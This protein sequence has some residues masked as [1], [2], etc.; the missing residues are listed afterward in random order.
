MLRYLARRLAFAVLLVFVVS[1][2]ALLLTRLAPGDFAS[3]L[4]G[5]GASPQT[6]AR[7]RARY[8]L[9]RPVVD[10]YVNWLG[11]AIRLDLGVSLMY[12]RPVRDLLQQRAANTALL[13]VTAL[14]LATLIGVPLGVI[15]GSRR[16]GVLPA[17]IRSA[18]LLCLS[19]PSLL[20]SLLLVLVAART[21]W[22]PIGGMISIDAVDAGWGAWLRDLLWHLPVPTLALALPVAATLERLQ[23]QATAE[24]LDEPFVLATLARGIPRSRMLWRDVLRVAIRP[25]ASIYGFVLAGLFSGSFVVE[26]VTAWPGLGRLMYEA[27]KARDLYLVAG[28]AAMGSVF[29]AIGSLVSDLVL[30]AVDPRL[31]GE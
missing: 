6:I 2:G 10:Q 18:S 26:I 3:D 20:T 25:V 24:A 15:S 9:D 1:S 16:R 22:F 28:C 27:L 8:G 31:A 7:E 21:G 5:A 23:A 30:A 4:F 12:G 14:V 29:L 17:L 11:R 13:A 19:L